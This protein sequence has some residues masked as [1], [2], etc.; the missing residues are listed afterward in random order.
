ML[1]NTNYNQ[2]IRTIFRNPL[3]IRVEGKNKDRHFI[4]L[5][6][7]LSQPSWS[8]NP[9]LSRMPQTHTWIQYRSFNKTDL[10]E[11]KHR[12]DEKDSQMTMEK[13]NNQYAKE[14]E[15]GRRF[16]MRRETSSFDLWREITLRKPTAS[17][18]FLPFTRRKELWWSTK[19]EGRTQ[20]YKFHFRFFSFFLELM[21]KRVKAMR[22]T[23]V[24]PISVCHF[25][26]A[27]WSRL[28]RVLFLFG[29]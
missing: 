1:T 2:W 11:H 10:K 19:D 28:G 24:Q 17:M 8:K 21:R 27:F 3:S 23:I 18:I 22:D 26:F 9:D 5:E 4:R 7:K 20:P 15:I 14:S 12:S 6:L 29:C 25:S 13:E 16:I